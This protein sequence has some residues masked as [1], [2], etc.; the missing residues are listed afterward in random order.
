MLR[1]FFTNPLQGTQ[2]L[3][4]HNLIMGVVLRNMDKLHLEPVPNE[5]NGQTHANESGN[6]LALSYKG[7]DDQGQGGPNY[8]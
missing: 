4:L 6:S 7:A 8:E 3:K 2:L 5:V 1:D